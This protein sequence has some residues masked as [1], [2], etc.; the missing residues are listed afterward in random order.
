[1]GGDTRYDRTKSEGRRCIE[2]GCALAAVHVGV[3]EGGRAGH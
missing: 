3:H 2:P 1:M